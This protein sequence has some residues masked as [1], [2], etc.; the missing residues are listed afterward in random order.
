MDPGYLQ[1]YDDFEQRHWW[2]VARREI[3]CDWIER[4]ILPGRC[5]SSTRWLDIGCGTGTLLRACTKIGS[6]I[7]IERDEQCIQLARS[8]G[9]EIL[10]AGDNWSFSSLEPFDLITLFDVLEH[11]NDETAVLDEA[12]RS[13][14]E[15]G[16]ILVTVPAL[17]SLWS[18]H[19]LVN[20]HFRRYTRKS[21]LACFDPDQWQIQRVSYYSSLL[22]PLIWLTRKLKNLRHGIDEKTAGHDFHYGPKLLDALLLTVFRQERWLLRHMA[23]PLG[24]SLILVARKKSTG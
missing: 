18:G 14:R 23:L 20:H 7:G 15:G 8:R 19:D 9:L 13:L 16:Q 6:K 11:L 5:A 1:Q 21:L 22:L 10:P 24:S 12:H 2:F 3:L 4:Y 17:R